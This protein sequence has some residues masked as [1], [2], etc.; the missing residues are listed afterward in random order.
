MAVGIVLNILS[1]EQFL[2]FNMIF[3]VSFLFPHIEAEGVL[4][5]ISTLP[6]D[7]LWNIRN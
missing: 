4:L 2:N 7:W 5:I 3:S 1:Q 6:G